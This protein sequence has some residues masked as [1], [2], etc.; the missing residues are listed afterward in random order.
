VTIDRIDRS[1]LP[2][3]GP[4]ILDEIRAACAEVTRRASSVTIDDAALAERAA[5]L[6]DQ[7][8]DVPYPDAY[9]RGDEEST[10]RFVLI[11]ESINFGSGW[12]PVLTKRD[13]S[14]GHMTMAAGLTDLAEAG[15]LWSAEELGNVD[16]TACAAAF[17]QATTG[18]AFDLMELFAIALRDLGALLLADYDGD[19]RALIADADHSAERLVL[20]LDRMPE[21]R[22]VATYGGLVVPFY[23]R[24]QLC[25]ATLAAAFEGAGLGRFDDLDRLTMFADNLVP[26]VL[27][28]DGVLRYDGELD[29]RIAAGELLVAGGS[30]EVEL[31]AVAL[32]A[33]ERL[34][35][36]VGSL[37][38]MTIDTILWDRGHEA[39][40][41]ARP[42]PRVRTTAF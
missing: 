18:E 33:V 38:A 11:L 30:E 21:F 27:W 37:D 6:D 7:R 40:Y 1:R 8:P 14:S 42:R 10:C 31:R 13:G 26:H 16:A 15:V 32:T 20:I 5:A 19:S 3:A 24:A 4:G 17:G 34:V 9:Y 12:H 36:A 29:R 35:G 25:S 39:R 2:A 41:K 22:D 23:K 28:C